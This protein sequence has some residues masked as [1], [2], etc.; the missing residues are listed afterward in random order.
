MP[1]HF[2]F[3]LLLKKPLFL[4]KTKLCLTPNLG[5][6]LNILVL[7]NHGAEGPIEGTLAG[8]KL[9]GPEAPDLSMGLSF[10]PLLG[11]PNTLFLPLSFFDLN[12]VGFLSSCS[13]LNIFKDSIS[14]IGFFS[15]V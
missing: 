1:F 4:S 13:W 3:F 7:C 10:P 6:G 2:K 11:P 12:L 5:L 8:V 14:D 9:I 15:G